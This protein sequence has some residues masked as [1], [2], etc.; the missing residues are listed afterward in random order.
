MESWCWSFSIHPRMLTCDSGP[1]QTAT[2]LS[3]SNKLSKNQGHKWEKEE[4]IISSPGE[5][6]K[7]KMRR[8]KM[9]KKCLKIKLL[10]AGKCRQEKRQ[11]CDEISQNGLKSVP[12]ELDILDQHVT[13]NW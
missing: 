11:G 2:D 9:R 5:D 6:E 12:K 4:Q 1:E 7:E 10:C 8:R 13:K 3:L